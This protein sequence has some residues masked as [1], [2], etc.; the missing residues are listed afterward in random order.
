MLLASM[1]G[2]SQNLM[3]QAADMVKEKAGEL[4]TPMRE[5]W[6]NSLD[7]STRRRIDAAIDA[8][9]KMKSMY[10]K[11][12]TLLSKK[13]IPMPVG[14]KSESCNYSL[15]IKELL[16]D[17]D[18]VTKITLS[19]MIPLKDQILGFDGQLTI[20]GNS[21]ICAPGKIS[22]IAPIALGNHFKIKFKEGTYAEFDCDGITK[23][24]AEVDVVM[25]TTHLVIYDDQYK[26]TKNAPVISTSLDFTD[27]DDFMLSLEKKLRFGFKKLDDW[28]FTIDRLDIDNSE[29]T[30]NESAKF[31]TGYFSSNDEKKL[32]KGFSMGKSSLRFPISFS[33]AS[34]NGTE[35]DSIKFNIVDCD[36]FIV[37]DKGFTISAQGKNMGWQLDTSKSFA[38]DVDSAEFNM[39]RNTIKKVSF[40]GDLNW[41]ALG[42]FSKHHYSALYNDADSVFEI[43]T[44]L[45]DSLDLRLFCAEI[46][47]HERTTLD[48]KLEK[49]K[50]RPSITA[51]GNLTINAGS[52]SSALHIP[53][54]D[55]EGMVIQA[56]KPYFKPGKWRIEGPIRSSL[57]G[58]DLQISNFGFSGDSLNLNAKLSFN[59]K[60]SANG[61]FHLLGDFDRMKLRKFWVSSFGVDYASNSFSI[62][63]SVAIEKNDT[64]FGNYFRGDM[65]MKIASLMEVKA[66]ALFG[67]IDGNKYFFADL[68]AERGG[69]PLFTIPPKIPVY[70]VGGGAY[71]HMDQTSDNLEPGKAPS[72]IY[73]KPNAN[74]GFGFTATMKFGVVDKNICDAKAMMD[75]QFTDSWGLKY[76]MLKGDAVF[77]NGADKFGSLKDEI[78]RQLAVATAGF[79]DKLSNITQNANGIVDGI[80]GSRLSQRFG[81]D[82]LV[83]GLDKGFKTELEKPEVAGQYPLSASLLMR[84]DNTNKTFSANLSTYLDM[85]IIHGAGDKNKLVEADMF[86]GN[87]DWY[88]RMGTPTARCGIVTDLKFLKANLTSYFMAGNGIPALPEPPEKVMSLLKDKDKSI[89]R[90]RSGLQELSNGKGMAF[91]AAFD[92]GVSVEPW[93][94]YASLNVG[95]GGEFLLTNYGTEAECKGREVHIGINGWY[96]SAQLWAYVEAAIGIK[97]KFLKK[98]RTFNILDAAAGVVLT[99]Q[100]PNP[101]Y[102]AGAVGC[103]YRV[104]GGLFKGTCSVKFEI[105]EPC[106]IKTEGVMLEQDII[107][108]LVPADGADTVSVFVSPQ[109]LLNVAANIPMDMDLDGNKTL[110]KVRVD[111][112]K[113]MKRDSGAEVKGK[114]STDSDGLI[115]SFDPAEA[116]E[117]ET[118]YKLE[119]KVSFLEYKDGNWVICKDEN[120]QEFTE[121][122][123]SEFKSGKRPDHI[124]PDHIL[125]SYPVDR[126]YNYYPDETKEGYICLKFNYSYLFTDVREGYRQEL[127]ISTLNGM[128]QTTGF[129]HLPSNEVKDEVYEIRFNLEDIKFDKQEIYKL[130]IMNMP[131][132]TSHNNENVSTGYIVSGEDSTRAITAQGTLNV[133]EPKQICGLN[134][135]TSKYKTLEAKVDDIDM[136]GKADVW[137]TDDYMKNIYK[138]FLTDDFFDANEYQERWHTDKLVHLEADLNNTSWYNK[139][140]Y[141]TMYTSYKE[142]EIVRSRPYNYPPSDAMSFF[143]SLSINHDQLDDSEIKTGIATGIYDDG[144][145]LYSVIFQ[146]DEDIN[147]LK[148]VVAKKR[149]SGVALTAAENK[150]LNYYWAE[151]YTPGDYPYI[152]SYRLPGKGKV[153]SRINKKFIY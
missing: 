65:D 11:F 67:K 23:I 6:Y 94:F 153:T 28:V 72:G 61:S 103:K 40:D 91:G 52:G 96:A 134:F 101:F 81:F 86:L 14:I 22:M 92:A 21:G 69:Q 3:D 17:N 108:S 100:G 141:K 123:I 116:L 41:K 50:F 82:K 78:N 46:Q 77:L 89:F 130:E 35:K 150:I 151:S 64:V 110:Y 43:S 121:T 118:D 126:M 62:K 42:R 83:K 105:G 19:C 139:S 12:D 104:L 57:G 10:K 20:T 47:L 2:Y 56:E 5:R 54:L 87:S 75:V 133:L 74:V 111:Y 7:M 85:G 79:S 73:Y 36:Y 102:F 113:L 88:F 9:N 107:A 33:K 45:G 119:G 147:V 1:A 80:Q 30:T 136:D 131:I 15:V 125:C 39:L 112:L 143:N 32:W 25:D 109:M 37:D 48:L 145:I 59:E 24:H 152:I 16:R 4:I 71:R 49:G 129:T 68:F 124:L 120:G 138:P 93:P 132:V 99:G 128:A 137:G 90:N 27:I 38:L 98:E 53:Q 58:F 144:L 127:R 146:C 60:I 114:F 55:F 148:D 122:R 34:Q 51:Y 76:V 26:P 95:A 63:G 142:S 66:S 8:G 149:D 106:E 44:N 84:Y 13:Q 115:V 29:V 70:G 117:S 97:V 18:S 135:R 31:P 140:I